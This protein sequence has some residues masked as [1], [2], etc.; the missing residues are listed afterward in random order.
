MRR[1]GLNNCPYRGNA[2]IYSSRPTTWQDE[3]CGLLFLQVLRCH[4][5]MRRHYRPLFMPHVP[6]WSEEPL[7]TAGELS[8]RIKE[9]AA[10]IQ[11]EKDQ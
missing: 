3:L 11:T 1:I 2:E 10:K 5:C 4:S 6:M 7:Q 9:L 8:Q